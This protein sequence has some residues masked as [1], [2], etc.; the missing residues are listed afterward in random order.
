MLSFLFFFFRAPLS[1]LI[2]VIFFFNFILELHYSHQSIAT[3]ITHCSLSLIQHGLYHPVGPNT[4]HSIKC[5]LSYY[6]KIENTVVYRE[7]TL[8]VQK[9]PNKF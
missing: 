9:K 5:N 4:L 7:Q 2:N 8:C 1:S 3:M 6:S